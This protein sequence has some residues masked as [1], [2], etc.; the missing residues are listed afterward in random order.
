MVIKGYKK[1]EYK[2]FIKEVK[3][4]RVFTKKSNA[5]IAVV[6]GLKCSQTLVNALNPD[7]QKVGDKVLT[8]VMKYVGLDGFTL[9]YNGEKHYYINNNIK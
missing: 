9:W 7:F 4:Y 8:K 3:D 2:K 6:L 1:V 5:E